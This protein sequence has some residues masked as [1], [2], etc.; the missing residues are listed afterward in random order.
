MNSNQSLETFD[1]V[2]SICVVEHIVKTNRKRERNVEWGKSWKSL[3]IDFFLLTSSAFGSRVSVWTERDSALKRKY[4]KQKKKNWIN[5]YQ[6][7]EQHFQLD[8]YFFSVVAFVSRNEFHTHNDLELSSSSTHTPKLG[9]ELWLTPKSQAT[10]N[11]T[12]KL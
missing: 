4:I 2:I 6:M 11:L 5:I 7:I 9:G 1:C 8:C 3:K 12:I 10:T